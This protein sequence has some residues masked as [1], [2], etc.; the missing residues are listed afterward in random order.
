MENEFEEL[1][2]LD[3][4][5]KELVEKE[6][7]FKRRLSSQ[8]LAISIVLASIGSIILYN[9]SFACLIFYLPAS[10]VL[11]LYRGILID[12]EQNK[13]KDFLSVFGYKYG[14]WYNLEDFSFVLVSTS[15]ALARSGFESIAHVLYLYSKNKEKQR[16]LLIAIYNG[17]EEAVE[18]GYKI[19]ALINFPV[20]VNKFN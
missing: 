15:G 17:R 16:N 10:I 14:Y 5:K 9:G 2:K 13:L 7:I 3:L 1:P 4:V 12:T 8:T 20:K 19:G 6:Y 18:N 11:F